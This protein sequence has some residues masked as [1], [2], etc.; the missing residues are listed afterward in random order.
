MALRVTLTFPYGTVVRMSAE[1]TDVEGLPLDPTTVTL[2]YLPPGGAE[3]QLLYGASAMVKEST[4]SYRADVLADASGLWRYRWEGTGTAQAV[5]EAT[6]KVAVN[7][8]P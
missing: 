3:V 5:D 7:N 2:R 8:F 6:F 4:G 1:F